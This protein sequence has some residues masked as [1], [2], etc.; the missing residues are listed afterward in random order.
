MILLVWLLSSVCTKEWVEED[1]HGRNS[2][3]PFVGDLCGDCDI[4]EK[5]SCVYSFGMRILQLRGRVIKSKAAL[6]FAEKV[7]QISQE[8]CK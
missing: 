8:N 1:L 3:F 5:T 4:I 7:T 2:S 6:P